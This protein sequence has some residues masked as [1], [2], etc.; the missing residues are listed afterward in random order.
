M[1]LG[2]WTPPP[3]LEHKELHGSH[4]Q[5]EPLQRSRHAI[6]MFHTFKQAGDEH[7]TYM[8]FGPFAD[9]AELGQ[10][11]DAMVKAR[12]VL[13]YAVLVNNETH[14]FMSYL[15]A[16][17]DV[18]VIEIGSIIFSPQ[19]Q[20]TTGTTEAV[21]LMLDHAFSNGYRRVEWK[22]DSLNARSRAAA[23]RLG[24]EYEGTFRN[25]T[26]YKGRNRD[27]SWYALTDEE[28]PLTERRLRTWLS[29]VN[30]NDDGSQRQRLGDLA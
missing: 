29:P 21:F 4:V 27:T 12:N 16:Q 5:L 8:S 20:R 3:L 1:D 14:G 17:P 30:F 7:W 18:G 24:F 26:H 23:E 6:P 22:C 10:V 25:A 19:L 13:P 15:R 9:A 11:F 28:W 2:R